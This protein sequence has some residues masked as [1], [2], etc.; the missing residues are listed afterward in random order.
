MNNLK[1]KKSSKWFLKLAWIVW[2][3]L[4]LGSMTALILTAVARMQ[5][6]KGLDIYRTKWLVED[7]SIGFLTFLVA[8]GIALIVGGIFRFKQW[9]EI[10]KFEK[11]YPKS[12]R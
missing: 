6:G 8:T 4:I 9:R 1:E 7:T 5:S 12:D 10:R 3:V 2:V 11:K